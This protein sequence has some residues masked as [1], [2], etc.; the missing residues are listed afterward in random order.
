MVVCLRV[1]PLLRGR[2]GAVCV[3]RIVAAYKRNNGEFGRLQTNAHIK[4][5][6]QQQQHEQGERAG[7]GPVKKKREVMTQPPAWLR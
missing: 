6:Q 1:F 5:F 4:F 2:L 3:C 7:G